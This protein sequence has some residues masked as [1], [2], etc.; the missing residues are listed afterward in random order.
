MRH[1]ERMQGVE[2]EED[3]EEIYNRAYRKQIALKKLEKKY[4]GDSKVN[5]KQANIEL[6]FF[7]QPD[8]RDAKRWRQDL[9]YV[10]NLKELRRAPEP[11]IANV[12]ASI[13]NLTELKKL[14]AIHPGILLKEDDNGWQPIHEAARSGNTKVIEYLIK[15]GADVNARTNFNKGANA[16]W[17]S[18][19]QNGLDHPST[20]LLKKA[21]GVRIAPGE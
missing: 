12:L 20:I 5:G 13:G 18:E 9:K 3:A 11:R 10:R 2:F 7:I 15:N 6:P 8:S 1:A 21:G 16:V 19:E 14:A 17:W 4:N